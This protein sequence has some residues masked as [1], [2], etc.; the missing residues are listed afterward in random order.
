MQ[1]KDLKRFIQGLSEASKHQGGKF[2]YAVSMNKA[3]AM[4][5]DSHFSQ[6]L[7]N[8]KVEEY[9]REHDRILVEHAERD[10]QG[11]PKFKHQRD[12]NWNWRKSYII[13]DDEK[14]RMNER[15]KELKEDYKDILEEYQKQIEE[16]EKVGEEEVDFEIRTVS[17]DDLPDTIT[18]HEL[19][20]IRWMIE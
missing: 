8:E 6:I 19:D 15:L 5:E 3:R 18:A 4:A 12:E 13:P 14:E 17:E 11:S 9:N 10:E 7:S 1:K 2:A 20:D 16:Y